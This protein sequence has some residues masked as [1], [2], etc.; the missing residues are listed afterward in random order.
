MSIDKDILLA[1]GSLINTATQAPWS[2]AEG[3]VKDKNGKLIAYIC[4]PGAEADFQQE[5]NGEFIAEIRNV[6]TQFAMMISSQQGIIERL[7]AK[8]IRLEAK[9]YDDANC[10]AFE[11][12]ND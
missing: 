7:Q 3:C 1:V 6:A 4:E 2:Y 8:V 5:V 9:L 12:S 11:E 10:Q